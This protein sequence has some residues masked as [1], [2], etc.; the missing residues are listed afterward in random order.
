MGSQNLFFPFLSVSEEIISMF[1]PIRK[2]VRMIC[3]SLFNRSHGHDRLLYNKTDIK[4]PHKLQSDQYYTTAKCETLR[5]G[6]VMKSTE[7][8]NNFGIAYSIMTYKDVEQVYRL[9]RSIYRP[10]N[11][12][13][14][15][16]DTKVNISSCI[17]LKV[18]TIHI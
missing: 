16:V 8:E 12:Y 5:R 3:E 11:Y 1:P 6:F 18:I 7:E 14:I 10:S 4:N 2:S 13:C 9:L 17:A 15:H